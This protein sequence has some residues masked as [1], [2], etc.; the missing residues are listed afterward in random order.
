MSSLPKNFTQAFG[1]KS[2]EQTPTPGPGGTCF[3]A[4]CRG[5]MA[6]LTGG[7]AA[8]RA[9]G[10][11]GTDIGDDKLPQIIWGFFS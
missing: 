2:V 4:R 8:P 7:V 9:P 1:K 6:S 11:V 3:V 10:L 5:F